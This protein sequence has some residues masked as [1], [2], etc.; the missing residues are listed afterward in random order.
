MTSLFLTTLRGST[1]YLAENHQLLPLMLACHYFVV[2][3]SGNRLRLYPA[4]SLP[5]VL[6]LARIE[7]LG[8]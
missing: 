8:V 1:W 6:R 4:G 3:E 2:V 7:T 5:R